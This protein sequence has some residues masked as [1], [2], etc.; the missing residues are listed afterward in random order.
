MF[1][2]FKAMIDLSLPAANLVFGAANVLL[3]IGAVFVLAGTIGV[4]WTGGIRERYA[5]E[6]ISNNEVQTALAKENAAKANEQAAKANENA[7]RV[8]LE[9]EKIKAQIAWRALTQH[10]ADAILQSV[11]IT[12]GM[13]TIAHSDNPETQSFAFQFARVFGAAKW[14]TH[15]EA[16]SYGGVLFVGIHVLK[17]LNAKGQLVVD[18]LKAAGIEVAITDQPKTSMV[19]QNALMGPRDVVLMIGSK[20]PTF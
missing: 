4:I 1:I 18:A 16:R 14:D 10:Q 8:T 13:I 17:P 9:A 3:I 12:P 20:P 15:V 7:A 2:R 5:N 19:A 6:R 11:A